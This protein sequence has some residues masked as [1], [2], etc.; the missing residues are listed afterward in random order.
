[1]HFSQPQTSK[2]L[3][4]CEEYNEREKNTPRNQSCNIKSQAMQLLIP[5]STAGTLAELPARAG[6]AV[7]RVGLSSLTWKIVKIVSAFSDTAVDYSLYEFDKEIWFGRGPRFG[8]PWMSWMRGGDA[9]GHHHH[10]DS[11]QRFARY[12]RP[13]KPVYHPN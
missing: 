13:S 9:L 8:N 6:W 12:R 7:C 5:Y 4:M 1:M 10:G 2:V 3:C 11:V